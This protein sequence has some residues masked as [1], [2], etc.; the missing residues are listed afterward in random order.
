MRIRDGLRMVILITAALAVW[1][2]VVV[3]Q[4]LNYFSNNIMAGYLVWVFGYSILIL[5]YIFDVN[6]MRKPNI[7]IA[8]ALVFLATDIFMFPLMVG[9]EGLTDLI[10]EQKMSAD[11]FIYE[12][13]PQTWSHD[14]RYFVTYVMFPGVLLWLARRLVS[15][16]QFST[17]VEQNL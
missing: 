8:W 9:R 11:V 2:Y 4:F 1:F 6:V 14:L 16:R 15:G 12:L 3:D 17:V 13:L 7:V 5:K 10:P